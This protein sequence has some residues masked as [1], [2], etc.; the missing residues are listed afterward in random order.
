MILT[1]WAAAAAENALA[2]Y[3]LQQLANLVL[4]YII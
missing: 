4:T 2:Q 1:K 3:I